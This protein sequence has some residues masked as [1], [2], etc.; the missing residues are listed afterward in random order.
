MVG[1]SIDSALAQSVGLHEIIVVDDGSTDNSVAVVAKLAET[2]PR[3]RLVEQKNAGANVARNNGIEHATGNW[4]AFLD[5]DDRWKPG[6]LAMQIAALRARPQAIASF[7]GITAVDGDRKL[8]DYDMPEEISLFELR[9]HNALG[10][11]STALINRDVLRRVGSFDPSLPSCQDWDLWLRL[12]S[13][14]EFAIVQQSLL[15]YEDGDH[16]RITG[17]FAKAI[18]GHRQVFRKAIKD[19]NS[20][21]DWRAI[22][23]SHLEVTSRLMHRQGM[24]RGA[25]INA[26][27]SLAIYPSRA[28]ARALRKSFS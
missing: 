6:K 2:E 7:T 26:A 23:A 16:D 1:A 27:M 24:F 28:A 18:A 15:Y 12:R 10:G 13:E 4:L 3:I 9:R 11:T 19:V 5:S 8:Y 21:R 25:A 14:G 20:L 22:R 17:N